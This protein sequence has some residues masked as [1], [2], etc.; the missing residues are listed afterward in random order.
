[1]HIPFP[2]RSRTPDT[3]QITLDF[4]GSDD[5]GAGRL[6][7]SAVA[8][9]GDDLWLGSDEGT[10]LLRL[11]RVAP[12]RWGHAVS[13]PLHPLLDL[14]GDDDEEIDV[15]GLAAAGG[16]LWVV[17]SHSAVRRKPEGDGLSPKQRL[18]RLARID[19]GGNRH[20]LAR[21]PLVPPELGAPGA[22]AI[23]R[24]ADVDGE[25]R[26][27]ARLRG[28]R[29]R[30]AL[31]RALRHDPHLAPSLD[32]PGKDNGFDVEGLA[33]LGDRVWLGLRGPVLRGLAVILAVVP[34]P[35]ADDVGRLRLRR[36]GP[37][38]RRY[39]RFFLDLHG[40]GVRELCPHGEDLLILAGPTM[41]LD[42]RA[43]VLRW[44][45]AL[46]ARGDALVERDQLEVLHEL[47]YGHGSDEGV[48]HPEGLALVD[49][50]GAPALLVVYDSPGR[51]RAVHGHAVTGD[52]LPLR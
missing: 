18:R 4:A 15:E 40:L 29:T 35:D 7:L 34:E 25:S 14:P 22:H 27:A 31:T 26:H 44:R 42:G 8:A 50:A 11:T 23:V 1:M 52:L 33:V 49:D 39:E 30:D 48:E 16:W 32:V 6:D 12:D 37:K 10:S 46:A 19:R 24:H 2:G 21:V 41:Q 5:G 28:G 3:R 38:G 17:G 43:V 13:V 51:R 45:G 9:V 36:A 47:S 20:L